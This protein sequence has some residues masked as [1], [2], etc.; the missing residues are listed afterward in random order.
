MPFVVKGVGRTG[1]VSWLS[2]ANDKWRL[3]SNGLFDG[4]SEKSWEL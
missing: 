3:P 4:V 1:T 2:D